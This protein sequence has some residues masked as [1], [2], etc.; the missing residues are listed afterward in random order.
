MKRWLI[1]VLV[2]LGVFSHSDTTVANSDNMQNV[3][4]HRHEAS[5]LPHSVRSKQQRKPRSGPTYPGGGRPL[6]AQL[7][8]WP[9]FKVS[10]AA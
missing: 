7:A 10:L 9:G 8:I 5:R 2:L 6:A 4:A 3:V 1:S